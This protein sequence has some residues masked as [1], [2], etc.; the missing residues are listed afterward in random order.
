MKNK[1]RPLLLLAAALC[2]LPCARAAKPDVPS[3][4]AEAMTRQGPS[5]RGASK[6]VLHDEVVH[7]ISPNGRDNSTVTY[8]ARILN[9]NGLD[10]ARFVIHYDSS[11]ERISKFRAWLVQPDGQ[12]KT[13]SI[14]DAIDTSISSAIYTEHRHIALSLVADATEGCVYAFEY[15]KEDRGIFGQD[16]WGFH[17]TRPV[18]LSR[19]TYKLPK[20][21][22]IKGTMLN[23]APV[24]PVIDAG[25]NTYT[26]EM[27]D[28]APVRFEEMGP[29]L[30][31]IMP[32]LNID[33]YPPPDM[34]K[35][36]IVSFSSWADVSSYNT[37]LQV[38]PGTPDT[39]VETKARE[40]IAG[41]GPGL[42]ERID[43]L[44]RCA[45]SINYISIQMNI[46][47]GGGYT[48]R[49]ARDVLKTGY[50]DCKDK[51]AL[52]RALLTSAGFESYP[53]LVY[54]GDRY[55]VTPKWPTPR[56]FNHVITAVKIDD[57]S[58]SS[59]AIVEHPKFGRLLFFDPTD[60]MTP[61]GD[62]FERN[63]GAL[64]LVLAGEDGEL[65]Q[66][67]VMP[68][69]A[70]HTQRDIAVRMDH[71]GSVAVRIN[72][73][74]TGQAAAQARARYRLSRTKYPDFIRNWISQTVR[75]AKISKAEA[76]D[77]QEKGAFDSEIEFVAPGYASMMRD[78]LLVFKP[79]FVSRRD[80]SPPDQTKRKYPVIIQPRSFAE[81]VDIAIP[82]DFDVDEMPRAVETA[83]SFGR[84]SMTCEFDAET[85]QVRYRRSLTMD[86]AEIP[87]KN[88]SRVRAFF[89]TIRKTEQAPVVLS[90]KS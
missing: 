9:R 7:V 87:A 63:Q 58:V 5:A 44:A 42:W 54:S 68:A 84:Y 2:F 62:L 47:R 85:R 30:S 74:M 34:P 70:N 75:L 1:N 50:G 21:W 24:E 81:S 49:L 37:K 31:R 10:S 76:V 48:P 65:V 36:P 71:F 55:R 40:L 52:L 14:K 4:L 15:S 66:L 82:A 28:L 90:R 17:S 79:A 16:T 12:Q 43:A 29:T 20:G 3:W 60:A 59:P 33:L 77:L 86:A 80:F 26:W 22:S 57:V 64:G 61:L 89:E 8:A 83:E 88:Y 39:S 19:L 51:T 72:E 23:H 78:K 13:Y 69:S 73:H 45:Q 6:L 35:P 53:V 38:A 18:S 67:P 25:T 41:A 32:R 27:R 11:V 56:Q 46:G